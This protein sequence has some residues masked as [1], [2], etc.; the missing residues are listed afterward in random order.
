[1][2]WGQVAGLIAALAF[3]A[4]VVFLALMLNKVT[5]ILSEAQ[6]MINDLRR[7]TVPLLEEVRSTVTTV[8]VEIERVDGIMAS[9]ETMA[10]SVSN[11]AR[12]VTVAT[13]N[14]IIKGL[15]FMTGAGVSLKALGR[16][17]DKVKG[18][19]RE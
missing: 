10:A 19:E 1:M 17:R 3:V 9:A 11:V 5:S 6:L 18:R 12:L 14:P 4:L 8:N 13:A 16:K 15:A 7:E 2:T